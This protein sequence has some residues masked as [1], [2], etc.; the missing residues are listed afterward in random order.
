[1]QDN[2]PLAFLSQALAL[3]NQ[4][5]SVYEK[6]LIAVLKAVEKWRHYLEGRPFVIKTDHESLKFLLQQRMHT[7]LQRKGLS[8]ML[9]L[10][11]VIQYRQGKTIMV[12]DALSR[13]FEEQMEEGTCDAISTVIPEWMV[14]VR[15]SYG[16]SE[17][18]MELLTILAVNPSTKPGF[19]LAADLLRYKGRLVVGDQEDLRLRIL[20]A[21]H[22]SA[23]GVHS[24]IKL[25]Y[26]RVEQLFY[27]PHLKKQVTEFVLACE[28]CQKCKTE[29]VAIPGLLQPLQIRSQVW[30]SV[31]MNFIE[32]FP[33]SEGK[34]VIMV[35]VDRLTKF[36]H[37]VG[38]SHPFTA[39]E[40]SRKFF[41]AMVK[42]HGVPQSIVSNRDKIFTS[43]FWKNFFRNLGTKLHMSTAYHPQSD[44]QSERVN[45]SE[46][47]IEYWR[48]LAPWPT[49]YSFMLA[50]PST[51]CFTS[52]YSRRPLV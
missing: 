38:L 20:Q 41:D 9:G 18:K 5:L 48:K 36:A 17:W 35:V 6:E 2:R 44:G 8:K 23:I 22:A 46:S 12:A 19:S 21:L 51:L 43:L 1:M 10:D 31:S 29:N 28:V 39:Q 50:A 11:Y 24:G 42:I 3:K 14:E 32:G 15:N 26:Q 37:F 27:W 49:D 45:Q 33:K 16:N 52:Q 25:T 40:V 4:G 13:K 7:H 30:Q 47:L 34:N